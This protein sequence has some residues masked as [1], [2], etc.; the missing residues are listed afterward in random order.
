V[1]A[2]ALACTLSSPALAKAPSAAARTAKYS[3]TP[4]TLAAYLAE[5][6][7]VA[8]EFAALEG[9][10]LGVQLPS[11]IESFIQITQSPKYV[12]TGTVGARSFDAAALTGSEFYAVDHTP[13]N[14]K[15]TVS[16]AA[17][18][19][20]RIRGTLAH[21]VFH[22]YELAM[23]LT[24]A[25]WN[26]S[27]APNWLVE[28]A[29]TWVDAD[30]VSR[31]E[32]PSSGELSNYYATPSRALFSRD[33]DGTGFFNHMQ[34]AGIDPWTRFK[35]MFAA[36]SNAAAYREAIG[37][38]LNFLT[39]EASV[40]FH[41]ASGWPW[42]EHPEQRPVHAHFQ[43]STLRVG[44]STRPV[45]VAP[46]A[47]GAYRLVLTSMSSKKPVLEVRVKKGYAR[48]KAL[49]G[50]NVDELVSGPLKLCSDP[51]GCSCPGHNEDYP[52]FR[53]GDLAVTGAATGAL[54][55]LIPQKRC[56]VLLG[57]RTCENLLPNYTEAVANTLETVA[58][59]FEPLGK[60]SKIETAN[61][62]AGFSSSTCLFLF[63]GTIRQR[64]LEGRNLSEPLEPG[65]T[66]TESYFYGSVASG[67]NVSRYATEAEAKADLQIPFRPASN[68]EFAALR[69]IGSEAWLK[70]R[71][72]SGAHGEPEH[73]SAGF[74][75]VRNLT[76][77]FFIAG[78]ANAGS[79]E[80]RTLLTQVAG[81]L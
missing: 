2:L 34:S 65:E 22:C 62:R 24:E 43:P 47:D 76:A 60:F 37:G 55:E 36:T 40:F 18:T 41:E 17:H 10:K 3:P 13:A 20:Q 51:Q 63:D 73:E 16:V 38:N 30:L 69:G 58:K 54:V 72:R 61:P 19:L 28:G 14:C 74:V 33:Y 29:A 32:E 57:P 48:I 8:Y 45:P 23:S 78:Q 75:R 6:K 39:T 7:K 53:E 46:Y 52:E 81:E 15:I 5:D 67:V 68:P 70:S 42:A 44:A 80:A 66:D 59:H 49:G 50:G 11:G 64:P 9:A 71:E 27:P 79:G 4:A 25:N 1:L 21:E 56:E 12:L 35:A 77:Y 26:R 31:T